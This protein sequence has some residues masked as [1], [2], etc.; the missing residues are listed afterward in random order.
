[1]NELISKTWNLPLPQVNK[2]DQKL[3]INTINAYSFIE[4]QRDL[5]FNKALM[6][7]DILIPDG[8]GIVYAYQFLNGIKI[9]KIAGY[10]L[11]LYE[12]D[13]LNKIGGKCFLLGSSERVLS[14]MVQRAAREYPNVIFSTYSPPYKPVFSEEDNNSMVNAVNAFSPDVLFIG[15]TA[16]K[17]EKWAAS[18]FSRLNAKHVCSIGAVFDFYAGTVERAPRWMIKFNL[19]WLYRFIKEPKRMWRRYLLGNPKFIIIILFE[20][21]RGSKSNY[22][23]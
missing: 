22:F 3:L 12:L 9:R 5:E 18:H 13:L 15:M 10:D 7:S 19:E 6:Q 23:R 21:L 16:P 8:V 14:L 11:F 17:Q 20:K 2:Y 4:A 1:V